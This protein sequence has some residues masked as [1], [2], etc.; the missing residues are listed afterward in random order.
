[1]TISNTTASITYLG[2]GVN[3]LWAYGFKIPDSGSVA[4]T[5]IDPD[6]VETTISATT[7]S[8]SGVGS[9]DGGV[10]TYPLTGSPLADGYSIR[11]DRAVTLTQTTG[12]SNQSGL[13]NSLIESAFDKLTMIAQDTRSISSRA[14]TA[15]QAVLTYV[16]AA[17][18]YAAAAA[19]SAANAAGV[20]AGNAVLFVAQTLTSGQKAQARNN[21]GAIASTDVSAAGLSGV[22][23]DLS[24]KPTLGSAAALTAGTAANNV[25]QLDA[26]AKLPA[27]DGSQLLNVPTLAGMTLLG[28]FNLT[29]RYTYTLSGLSLAQYKFLLVSVRAYT[30]ANSVSATWNGTSIG[31]TNN[32]SGIYWSALILNELASGFTW[33]FGMNNTTSVI[34]WLTGYTTAATSITFT[35]GVSGQSQGSG[36]VYIYGVK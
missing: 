5:V 6:A 7:F 15:A 21:I 23:A 22:Y 34:A 28:S 19:T 36:T 27:V 32:N 18:A 24:G 31:W 2:N 20:A 30:G 17:A 12:F 10:V 3:T 35:T 25:V 11:I 4:V 9:D 1:M 14:I 13:I 8:I 16:N 33:A 26:N 29:G